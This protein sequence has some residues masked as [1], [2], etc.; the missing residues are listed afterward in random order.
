MGITIIIN[1]APLIPPGA[2]GAGGAGA[3]VVQL[4]RVR[5]HRADGEF[6]GLV[7][8]PCVDWLVS[9]SPGVGHLRWSLH[10]GLA[11]AGEGGEV[12][13]IAVGDD[14]AVV[15]ADHDDSR[16]GDCSCEPPLC[17]RLVCHCLWTIFLASVWEQSLITISR[18]CCL[19]YKYD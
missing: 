4:L 8:L 9:T 11:V 14:D 19:K 5:V 16:H 6:P 12:A 2:E 3:R 10:H 13:V 7:T 17:S 1:S 15:V 18:V